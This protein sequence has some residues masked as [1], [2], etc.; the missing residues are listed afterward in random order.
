MHGD[1]D[2]FYTYMRTE[3]SAAASE[4]RSRNPAVTSPMRLRYTNFVQLNV[5]H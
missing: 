5:T 1:K 4:Y 3:R 2:N